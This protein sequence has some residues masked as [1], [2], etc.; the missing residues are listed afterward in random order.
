VHATCLKTDYP[1][2]RALDKRHRAR[3][4]CA[5]AWHVVSPTAVP[6]RA[7]D[8]SGKWNQF[9]GR[10]A[11]DQTCICS[12][13]PAFGGQGASK[14]GAGFDAAPNVDHTSARVRQARRARRVARGRV[15]PLKLI[16]RIAP[17]GWPLR[18][19]MAATWDC[20]TCCKM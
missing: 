6:P 1:Q 20:L 4:P 9:S 17:A 7:Q 5:A 2:G 8:S 12:G 13:N 18:C 14:Q 19:D 3:R 10:Y 11:W 15:W 16:V